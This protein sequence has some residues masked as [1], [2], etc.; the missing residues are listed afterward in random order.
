MVVVGNMPV[1]GELVRL[2]PHVRRITQDNP[3][4]FTGV[5]TNTHLV[6]ERRVF[7]L[8]PG[9]SSDRHFD[10]IVEAVGDA[11]VEAVI[12]THHHPDHWPLAPRLAE[13]FGAPTLGYTAWGDYRP[14]RTVRDGEVL[15]SSEVRLQAVHTPGH[16]P[17]HLCYLLAD[18]EA[19]FS[20]DHVM[21]WSTSVIAPPGGNL[22]DFLA[23]LEK[24]AAL[25]LRVMYPAHGLP[26]SDPYARIEE[27]RSHRELRTRQA[28][29]ALEAGL[30]RIPDLV[31]RIYAD[32]DPRLH[33][34][35]GASLLAHLHALVEQ[36]RV[37]VAAESADPL[38][39][40]YE[41]IR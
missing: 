26:I 6:G 27:L 4:L 34:A 17:D 5:G 13:H 38:A 9:P 30:E 39:V 10:R 28:I 32:V 21:G 16:A 11:T 36:G 3:S 19:L 31:A 35:A 23:S 29:E 18:E 24:L 22:G 25:R 41:L 8:D 20:G 7:L 1:P 2:S 40:R 37:R 15:D 33:A 12:P 14:E